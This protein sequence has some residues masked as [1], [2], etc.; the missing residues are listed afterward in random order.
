MSGG[1]VAGGGAM[2]SWVFSSGG[3]HAA[4]QRA[5]AKTVRKWRASRTLGFARPGARRQLSSDRLRPLQVRGGTGLLRW[6]RPSTTLAAGRH[7]RMTAG[8]GHRGRRTHGPALAPTPGVRAHRNNL[9]F[10][11]ALVLLLC[12]VLDAAFT[13]CAVQWGYA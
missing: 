4:R 5:T 12:N 13:L 3:E 1:G 2:S 11:A 8:C 6:G 10:A 9:W 7:R